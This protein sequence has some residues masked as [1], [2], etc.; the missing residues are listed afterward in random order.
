MFLE[1]KLHNM[2]DE[3]LLEQ[4]KMRL[5]ILYFGSLENPAIVIHRKDNTY[6]SEATELEIPETDIP[7]LGLGLMILSEGSGNSFW[8]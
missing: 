5:H 2:S 1:I 4:E 8:E 6:V 3:L 7:K